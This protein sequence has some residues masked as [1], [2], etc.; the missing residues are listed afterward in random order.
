MDLICHGVTPPKIFEKYIEGIEKK[1]GEIKEY[2]FRT[3]QIGWRGNNIEIVLKNGKTLLNDKKTISYSKLYA[4]GKHMREVCYS[5]PYASVFR[6]GDFTLGDF[7]GIE[8]TKSAFNDNKGCSLVF[9]STEKAKKIMKYVSNNALFE[10]RDMPDVIQ[11]NLVH[12]TK[13]TF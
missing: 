10:E 8:H 13:K 9:V 3:K 7:W 4:S 6:V 12:P 2:K 1:V 11:H 5:C